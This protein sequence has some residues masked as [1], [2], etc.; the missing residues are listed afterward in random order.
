M[1][2]RRVFSIFDQPKRKTQE[3]EEGEAASTSEGQGTS[4]KKQKADSETR[5]Y[6]P[7]W[8]NDFLWHVLEKRDDGTEVLVCEPCRNNN[9]KGS[10]CVQC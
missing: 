3:P 4:S 5:K 2:A 10:F 9:K 1:A 8:K 6:N 7:S